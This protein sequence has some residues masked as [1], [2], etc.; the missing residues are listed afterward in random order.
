MIITRRRIALALFDVVKGVTWVIPGDEDKPVEE[1]Q[2]RGFVTSGRRVK[3]FSDVPAEFQP[4]VFQA[5]H[6]EGSTQR[7]GLPYK[8]VFQATWIIYHVA[9]K[10]PESVPADENN[11]I[12][13]AVFAA[14]APK[15]T[16]EGFPSR[17]TLGGLVHHAWIEG[18][19]FKDPGD[20]DEQGLLIIPVR[21]LVP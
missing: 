13:D 14:F 5:E 11:A 9:G 7:T 15:P 21:A 1:Q 16:D 6:D 4:A 19:I 3:L 20:L 17:N 2:R 8:G 18:E 12:L 10:E